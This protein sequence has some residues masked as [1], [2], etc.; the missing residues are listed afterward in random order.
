MITRRLVLA[1]AAVAGV[2]AVNE[3]QSQ[4]GGDPKT[5]DVDVGTVGTPT[6]WE[7]KGGGAFERA[8]TSIS[9]SDSPLPNALDVY[10]SFILELVKQNGYV[11]KQKLLING[12]IGSFDISQD[13]PYYN[14]GLFRNFSD[15]VFLS[16]PGALGPANRADR[17]SKQYEQIVRIAASKIDRKY[18]EITSE[19][20]DLQ[21][22]FQVETERLTDRIVK[23]NGEWLK[24]A[25][26]SG[27]KPED[28]TYELKYINFLEGVRYADQI[29]S[30]TQ[31]IDMI[32]G[33]LDAVRRSKFDPQEQTLLDIITE[34]SETKKLVRPKRP[35]FERTVKDVTDLTFA[36]PTLRNNATM[37]SSPAMYPLGDLVK[38]LKL[39]GVRQISITKASTSA[40]QHDK[41]WSAGGS[42]SY[43]FF[44]L[45]GGGSGSSH[46]REDIK[47]SGGISISFENMAEYL[48]D[49]ELWFNPGI[50][51]D[52]KLV[53]VISKVPGIERLQ[54]VAVSLII[55]RGLTLQ[56]TF[57]NSISTE[58]W[59]KQSFAA[60]GGVSV[61]GFSFG[62]SGSSS[63]YDYSLDVSADGKTVTFKDDPQL[64][65]ILAVRLEQ[66]ASVPKERFE[67]ATGLDA[68]APDSPLGRFR[69]GRMS[70]K[71]L[72]SSKFK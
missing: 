29:A 23:I 17:F 46:F 70:Y 50:F 13:T 72:Q 42:V 2:S 6:T 44:S 68:A 16:S 66:L 25:Q 53:P 32:V 48:V 7:G 41:S 5:F 24:V 35:T 71:D 38:F 56:L 26:A 52:A 22:R 36:N 62:G 10:Y 20:D 14:E 3:A 28:P 37:D 69:S 49:R 65:R 61:F 4:T 27:V 57:E 15:R 1:G 19:V 8:D 47:K 12:T 34:L 39:P 18:K 45:G 43:G 9:V 54:Y 33:T 30:Y 64:T 55:A 60:S 63:S 67:L 31:N 40:A 51:S 11:D 59:S 58:S 21:R